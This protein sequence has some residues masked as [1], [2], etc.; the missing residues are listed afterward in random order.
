MHI[1]N[2]DEADPPTYNEICS[3]IN[4]LKINKAAGTDNTV[5]QKEKFFRSRQKFHLKFVFSISLNPNLK[6]ENFYHTP[7]L[8]EIRFFYKI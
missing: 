8:R 6:P 5:L 1:S 2:H 3:V 4:K 7:F